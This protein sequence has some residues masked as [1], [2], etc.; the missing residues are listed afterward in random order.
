[1]LADKTPYNADPNVHH[2]QMVLGEL[3]GHR[4]GMTL[5]RPV[6]GAGETKQAT[7]GSI[8]LHVDEFPEAATLLRWRSHEFLEIERVVAKEWRE[9]LAQ[10][11]PAR[12][13]GVLKNV[14][15]TASRAQPLA[16]CRT[17]AAQ[18]IRAVLDARLQ[19][20]LAVLPRHR[21]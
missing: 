11:D 7:D 15:P 19:G 17:A 2:R 5:G 16:S 20:R 1:M 3:A 10:Q 8:G 4:F 9:E 21:P 18:P 6:V 13:V 12:L 14:L